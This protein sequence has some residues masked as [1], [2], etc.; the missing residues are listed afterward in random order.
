MAMRMAAAVF[1]A[2]AAGV[3]TAQAPPAFGEVFEREEN[4]VYEV[5]HGVGLVMDI[6]RPTGESN[7]LAL[8]DTLSGA[9]HSGEAQVRD[10]FMATVFHTMTERGFTVFMVRPGSRSKFT[11]EEMV[12]NLHRGVRWI[13]H[14]A[15]EYGIDPDRIGMM[16]A[17][18]GGHLSLL[19][20]CTADDGDSGA[21]DR[22]NRRSSR[23]QAV[24]VLFPPTDFLDWGGAAVSMGR[25]GDIFYNCPSDAGSEE[26]A[27]ERMRELSPR[28]RIP[29]EGEMPPMLLVHGDADEVVPLQ[30]SEVF[31]EA[32]KAAGH[33]AELWVKEGGGHPWLTVYEEVALMAAWFEENL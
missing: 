28:H 3:A 10:H 4:V 6:F 29:A 7:G 13:R 15:H 2:L 14:N 21:S 33:N 9:W 12:R 16:G 20:A 26:E 23:V 30:Q 17:S 18:A 22:V 8:V 1:L 24:A 31:I 32:A 25:L 11:A 19:A 27:I 5:V